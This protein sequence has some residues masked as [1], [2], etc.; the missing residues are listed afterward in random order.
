MERQTFA[1]L[2]WLLAVAAIT[3]EPCRFDRDQGRRRM[4]VAPG[5]SNEESAVSHRDR[6]L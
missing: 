3:R 5:A 1:Q 6:G 4:V 2:L